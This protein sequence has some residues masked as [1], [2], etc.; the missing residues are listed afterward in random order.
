M[1]AAPF[2]S[3]L[4]L[5]ISYAYISMMGS[6]GLREASKLAILK[7]NYMAK[8][9]GQHY[10]V[11]YTGEMVC[12]SGLPRLGG[13][14]VF[15]RNWRPQQPTEPQAQAAL[16]YSPACADSLL[17]RL[18]LLPTGPNGT[19]A[20]EF[21]LDVRPLEVSAGVKAEDI[22]KRLMDYGYHA[23][24]MSW[25]VPGTLMIEPTESESKAELDR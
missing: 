9:L 25:P 17:C 8:V 21:I 23:P 10:P 1:A 11:L 15:A 7:A 22:A 16:S 19:C 14:H 13:A 20:H 12:F 4:I 3:S 24:T 2:G 5:P 6:N 18:F